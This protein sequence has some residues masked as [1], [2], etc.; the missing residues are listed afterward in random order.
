MA[1]GRSWSPDV[2]LLSLSFLQGQVWGSKISG[3]GR[4]LRSTR[5][6]CKRS[7]LHRGAGDGRARSTT[8][9]LGL[10]HGP[11]ALLLYGPRS[12]AIGARSEVVRLC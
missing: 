5:C 1:R 4:R 11:A 12:T 9:L 2:C 8:A 6:S 3:L 10:A 7:E